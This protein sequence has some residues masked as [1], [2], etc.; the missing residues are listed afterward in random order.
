MQSDKPK[1]HRKGDSFHRRKTFEL[2]NAGGFDDIHSD[3]GSHLAPKIPHQNHFSNHNRNENDS[4]AFDDREM[5]L[6]VGMQVKV[7]DVPGLAMIWWIQGDMIGVELESSY[8][9]SDGMYKNVR[10]FLVSPNCATFIARER[11]DRVYHNLVAPRFRPR[12]A[13]NAGDVAMISSKVGVG[14]VRYASSELIGCHLNEA[15]G[16]SDGAF[17][18]HRYF[19]TKKNHAIFVNPRDCRKIDA[20]TLLEKLNETVVRLQDLE[21]GLK[22]ATQGDRE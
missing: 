2:N 8:G 3:E 6:H 16:N 17:K 20:E 5:D 18:G 9:D 15:T 13:F 14:V 4:Y 21:E 11:V 7:R 22:R 1:T 19:Q 10:R 12:A